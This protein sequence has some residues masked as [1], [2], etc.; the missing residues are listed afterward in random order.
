MNTPFAGTCQT[1]LAWLVLFLMINS[2]K[3]TLF[4]I[5]LRCCG[6]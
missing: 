2:L 1:P 3:S 5:L 4:D 6:N